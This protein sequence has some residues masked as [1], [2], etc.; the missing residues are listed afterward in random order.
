MKLTDYLM[1]AMLKSLQLFMVLLPFKCVG[2]LGRVFGDIMYVFVKP[3]RQITYDNL[4]FVY[5]DKLSKAEK[6]RIARESFRNAGRNFTEIL[7]LPRV[8]KNNFRKYV[9]IDRNALEKAFSNGKGVIFMTMHMSNWEYEPLSCTLNGFKLASIYVPM[10]NKAADKLLYKLRATHGDVLIPKDR[11]IKKI[12][13]LLAQNYG[14]G[15]LMD[16]D[17]GGKGMMI[18][19]LGKPASTA[20]GIYT[21]ARKTGAY[22][23]GTIM[24]RDKN[25]KLIVHTE[26]VGVLPE[27]ESVEEFLHK[28]NDMASAYIY[29]YPEQWFWM[30]RRFKTKSVHPKG[31]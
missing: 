22:I 13:E 24:V 2:M 19:F 14:I 27:T 6:K 8:N 23:L 20:K 4:D 16:Q 10:S 30:H 17:A 12:R 1:Y 11:S 3:R 7:W 21:F 15:M 26:D 18:P 28:M 31:H 9:E 29:K 5:G 25:G